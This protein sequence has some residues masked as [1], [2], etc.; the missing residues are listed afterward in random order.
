MWRPGVV[1]PPCR[2]CTRR[3]AFRRCVCYAREMR[4]AR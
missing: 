3:L 1:T 4:T 2:L